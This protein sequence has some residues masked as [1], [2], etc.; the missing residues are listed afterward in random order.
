MG[1]HGDINH[2][3]FDPDI[4][5]AEAR[6]KGGK[7]PVNGSFDIDLSSYAETAK[8]VEER[9]PIVPTKIKFFRGDAAFL[10][11][12]CLAQV[13]H[14][15]IDYPTTEHA[16][17][18]AKTLDFHQRYEISKIETPGQAKRAGRKVQLRPDWEQVKNRIMWELTVLKFTNHPNLKKLLLAT[19]NAELIEGNTWGD[20]Y[21]GVC[22]GVGENHLGF[23]LARVRA[24]L[25]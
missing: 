7:K 8:A 6:F 23:I 5:S 21:W 14:D 3:G 12:F 22:N 1:W 13:F 15:G 11:N 25:G 16:F 20:T 17:Q 24:N 10:S 2:S 9:S 18:A 19:G 4:A